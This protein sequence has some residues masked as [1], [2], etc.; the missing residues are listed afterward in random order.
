MGRASLALPVSL[1]RLFPATYLLTAPPILDERLQQFFFRLFQPKYAIGRSR[2]WAGSKQ[3]M[4]HMMRAW[5][6]REECQGTPPT[7]GTSGTISLILALF[8][9]S[10]KSHT[11]EF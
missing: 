6:W 4:A 8:H 11:T 2:H 5:P 7:W 10:G 1:L 9:L 3:G